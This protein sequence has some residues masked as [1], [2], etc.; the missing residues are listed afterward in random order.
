[1]LRCK[2]KEKWHW[3]L[4]FGKLFSE[5]ISKVKSAF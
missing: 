1:M 5:L 2:I 3:Q 4:E